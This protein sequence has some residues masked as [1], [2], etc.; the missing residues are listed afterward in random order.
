MSVWY[1]LGTHFMC[2][3]SLSHDLISLYVHYLSTS[4]W[5]CLPF[6]DKKTEAKVSGSAP[7][8]NIRLVKETALI[9]KLHILNHRNI[10][11]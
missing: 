4:E 8:C 10:I 7:G 5:Y 2:I 11:K 6:A 1:L 9:S 3:I